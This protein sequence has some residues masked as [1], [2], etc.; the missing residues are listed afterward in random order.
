MNRESAGRVLAA[1]Q[2]SAQAALDRVGSESFEPLWGDPRSLFR[3]RV[4]A[5]SVVDHRDSAAVAP[6]QEVLTF[7]LVYPRIVL[8]E[9]NTHR[10]LSRSTESSRAVPV[11]RR[12]AQ[13]SR[14]PYRPLAALRNR[15]GMQA[16]A[17]MG[18]AEADVAGAAWEYARAACTVAMELSQEA[19]L[20]KEEANRLGETFA[21]VR[22]VVTATDWTNFYALRTHDA[23][24]PVIRFL[25]RAM[26]V[27][28]QNSTPVPLRR[29]EWH[30][31]FVP[32]GADRVPPAPTEY[33]GRR[34]EENPHR[35]IDWA[36]YDLCRRSSA[37]CARVSYGN[38]DGTP[39]TW[40]QDDATW[41]KLV[42]FDDPVAAAECQPDAVVKADAWPLRPLH[43]SA[44]EHAA[45]PVPYAI[46]NDPR[47][48]S[49]LRGW[50][51]FRK[52]FTHENMGRFSP[53]VSE[54]AKW[55]AE[56][57]PEVFAEADPY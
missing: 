49:N 36:D 7:R 10:A 22:T 11:K 51:Q 26:Y 20:H 24:H 31:P 8:A 29:G 48:R 40:L 13:L 23:A 52:L 17:D 12:I 6:G 37:R 30:L 38:V 47:Y 55:A 39:S 34:W 46:R 21:L 19:G 35:E 1:L 14:T 50:L 27:A 2:P 16:G 3:V 33:P 56:V 45:T 9:L 28:H 42:G 43:A 41:A 15:A 44:L 57:P 25:A 5:H 53:P 54:V 18:S 4:A 32:A